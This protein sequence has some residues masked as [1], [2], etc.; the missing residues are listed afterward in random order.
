MYILK[1][2]Y[3]SARNLS[4]KLSTTS[5]VSDLIRS[6]SDM[7]PKRVSVSND[8]SCLSRIQYK[9][10]RS[11]IT[12]CLLLSLK[13]AS[14]EVPQLDTLVLKN[15]LK[16]CMVNYGR[17][18][19]LNVRL[20]INGGQKNE[21]SC[22]VG[23]SKLIQ[24]LIAET[25]KEKQKSLFKK[26]KKIKCELNQGQTIISGNCAVKDFSKQMSLLSSSLLKLPFKPNLIDKITSNL[27]DFNSPEKITTETVFAAFES[28]FLYGSKNPLGRTYCQYAIQKVLPEQLR[29]FYYQHYNPVNTSLL[30]CGNFDKE[31]IKKLVNR[32]FN[33]WKTLRKEQ[34]V[35]D[36]DL[37]ILKIKSKTICF[38]NKRDQKDFQLTWL[39]AAPSFRSADYYGFV[40]ACALFDDFIAVKTKMKQDTEKSLSF[41]PVT[42]SN[43]FI[44]MKWIS[45]TELIKTISFFDTLLHE[46][47]AYNSSDSLL[48][49]VA[50]KLKDG[51]D[52]SK[53]AES[54]LCFYNPLVYPFESR[55]NYVSAFSVITTDNI[56]LIK[57]KYFSPDAYKLMIVGREGP[58]TDRLALQKKIT[59][60][61]STDFQTCDET[62]IPPKERWKPHCE[63]ARL[64]CRNCW[65]LGRFWGKNRC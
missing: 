10:M 48:N 29:E 20:V 42:Y 27:M 55:K 36:E 54:I 14:Q 19:V 31:E 18:S 63:H 60:Y 5:E 53:T 57:Q 52:S 40:L 23:Y 28:L 33:R 15:G 44:E 13:L 43:N 22:Q 34:K 35:N 9:I 65:K 64:F 25:L 47:H 61:Q 49:R 6:R 56:R 32:H 41:G 11:L 51:A 59:K 37:K 58:E 8:F 26:K 7:L 21:N 45:S 16:V 30:I 4:S 38:I 17:D 2:T 62:C 50:K 1:P 3:A 39:Q 46:F 24:H 12:A